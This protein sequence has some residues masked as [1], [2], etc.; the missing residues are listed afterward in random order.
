MNDKKLKN[1]KSKYKV[2]EW[3]KLRW[4]D[5]W[6]PG[7]YK[8]TKISLGKYGYSYYL[9]DDYGT[10]SMGIQERYGEDS[11]KNF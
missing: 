7:K 3:V 8:I 11:L 10:K 5:K 2:G 9:K 1:L 6:L 4:F